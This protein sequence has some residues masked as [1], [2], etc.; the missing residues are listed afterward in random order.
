[1]P[2]SSTRP[3]NLVFV[4]LHSAVRLPEGS[5]STVGREARAAR[6]VRRVLPGHGSHYRMLEAP[7]TAARGRASAGPPPARGP[8]PPRRRPPDTPGGSTIP[9]WGSVTVR[10]SEL[11][12]A[13]SPRAQNQTIG[14][15][16]SALRPRCA[17]ARI[18]RSAL[19]L[20]V[21][22]LSGGAR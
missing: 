15:R 2:G 7:P 22:I 20:K 16:T 6:G 11:I 1:M 8:I 21:W 4:S 12:R 14:A 19:V 17:A 5:H 10:Y 13:L 9:G 18:R 3:G